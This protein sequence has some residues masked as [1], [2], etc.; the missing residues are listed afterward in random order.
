MIWLFRAVPA[1]KS[2]THK[3]NGKASKSDSQS[4]SSS[5]DIRGLRLEKVVPPACL[6]KLAASVLVLLATIG[7]RMPDCPVLYR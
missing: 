7:Y 3:G 4:T 2:E 5:D 1:S 6:A